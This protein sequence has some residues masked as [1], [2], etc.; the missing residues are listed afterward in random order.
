MFYSC[1]IESIF[2]DS[3]KKTL[4]TWKHYDPLKFGSKPYE[5]IAFIQ[6]YIQKI[7]DDSQLPLF[8][9]EILASLCFQVSSA[10]NKEPLPEILTEPEGP[11]TQESILREFRQKFDPPPT[12]GSSSM[13]WVMG[14]LGLLYLAFQ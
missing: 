9:V 6:F 3:F 1:A 14:A 2:D 12:N 4:T 10:W 8:I 11:Q 13:I 7:Q 5:K